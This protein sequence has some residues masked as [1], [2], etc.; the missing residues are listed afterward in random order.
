[1]KWLVLSPSDF[2]KDWKMELYNQ[3]GHCF[4][5]VLIATV[6]AS[7]FYF[8]HDE[9]PE[10]E[11]LLLFCVGIYVLVIEL[12]LQ[13]WSGLDTLVDVIFV[14]FGVCSTAYGLDEKIVQEQ[15][16]LEPNFFA[17]AMVLGLFAF[18]L[19]VHILKRLSDECY[20]G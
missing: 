19:S 6:A 2:R 14:S 4:L 9:Y 13:K 7:C 3:I 5:G 8:L 11:L 18:T 17:L 20:S 1:M 10:K 12:L 15:V 16:V